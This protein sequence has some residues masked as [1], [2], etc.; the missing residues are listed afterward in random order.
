MKVKKKYSSV[1]YGKIYDK[2]TVEK[3]NTKLNLF[4]LE[5]KM[6]AID[7][8]NFRIFSTIIIFL[9]ALILDCGYFVSPIIAVIYFCAIYHIIIENGLKSRAFRLENEAMHFFEVLTLSLETGRN[10]ESAV[11]TTCR[12]VDGALSDEFKKSLSEISFGKSLAECLGNMKYNIPSETINNIIIS[13]TQSNL[14]GSGIINTLYNQIDY[15]REKKILEVKAQISKVPT[16]ISIISVL[17]FVPLVLMIILS[18]IILQ[19]IN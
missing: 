5:K 1:F 3:I 10:L 11:L 17:F 18:P 9:V 6:D 4:G 15:L 19:N 16:K 13:I 7:F 12:N 14:F 8:L 2:K